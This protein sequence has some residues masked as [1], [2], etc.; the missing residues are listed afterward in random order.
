M[1]AKDRQVLDKIYMHICSVLKY[2]EHCFYYIHFGKER[3]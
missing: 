2:C 3:K 1:E